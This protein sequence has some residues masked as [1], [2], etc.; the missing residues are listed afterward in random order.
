MHKERIEGR[1]AYNDG[2]EA[3]RERNSRRFILQYTSILSGLITDR[4]S[5]RWPAGHMRLT[6]SGKAR[7]KLCA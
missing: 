3:T 5:F 6:Q 4:S 2:Q 7:T 1:K